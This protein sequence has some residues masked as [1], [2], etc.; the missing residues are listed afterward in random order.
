MLA[1]IPAIHVEMDAADFGPV[2]AVTFLAVTNFLNASGVESEGFMPALL[3][4]M[5][6]PAIIVGILLGR[7]AAGGPTIGGLGAV[8]H[9]AVLGRRVFLLPGGLTAGFLTGQRGY[10]STAPFPLT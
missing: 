3:A 4:V 5:E 9:E 6:S 2:S 7:R 8:L 10:E 1:E